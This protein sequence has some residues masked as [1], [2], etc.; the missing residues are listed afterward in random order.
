MKIDISEELPATPLVS[1][2]QPRTSQ[3]EVKDSFQSNS[4]PLLNFK[5]IETSE[6]VNEPDQSPDKNA[7]QERIS[8]KKALKEKINQ[9]HGLEDNQT[10][11]KDKV[12]KRVTINEEVFCLTK[13][14]A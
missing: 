10:D 5:D 3:V 13:S 1:S 2:A 4:I 6:G 9:R 7:I 14:L 8:M 12:K 11:S